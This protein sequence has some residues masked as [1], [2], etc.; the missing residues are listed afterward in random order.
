LLLVTLF[1]VLIPSVWPLILLM[2]S[3]ATSLSLNLLPELIA[4]QQRSAQLLMW[5]VL[6]FALEPNLLSE[7]S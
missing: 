1:Q 5:T 3:M 2:L 4:E 7:R 6:L